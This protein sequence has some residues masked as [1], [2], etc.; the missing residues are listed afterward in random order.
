MVLV[1]HVHVCMYVC[2]PW[3][4]LLTW[5]V[6]IKYLRIVLKV[7]VLHVHVCMCVF[8]GGSCSHGQS[9]PAIVDGAAKHLIP[10]QLHIG[11][12]LSLHETAQVMLNDVTRRFTS[13]GHTYG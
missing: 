11:W 2:I 8:P 12:V 7:L 5:A 1:L 4:Q 13:N 9:F 3:W 10:H 6:N